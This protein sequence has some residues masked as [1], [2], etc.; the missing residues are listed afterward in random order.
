MNIKNSWRYIQTAAEET[1]SPVNLN[2]EPVELR[3][4][5]NNINFEFIPKPTIGGAKAEL[6]LN[7]FGV[8]NAGDTLSLTF[9]SNTITLVASQTPSYGEFLTTLGTNVT[10][11][12]KSCQSVGFELQSDFNINSAY[13]I[14]ADGVY[15]TITAITESPDF[16]ITVDTLPTNI[17][18]MYNNSGSAEFEYQNLV[19]YSVFN[20]LYVLDYVYGDQN[21]DKQTADFVAETTSQFFGD[22]IN[23][24]YQ[25]SLGDTVDV[26]LPKKVLSPTFNFKP[27][28]ETIKE[29]ILR[30]YV[31]LYGDYFRYV[32]NGEKKKRT[33][34][35]SSIRWVQN[36]AFNLLDAYDLTDYTLYP[37]T[38]TPFSF[39]TNDC[40]RYVTYNSHQYIQFIQKKQ[41]LPVGDLGIEVE[42]R[43][44]DGSTTTKQIG[45]IPSGVNGGNMSIDVS[46]LVLGLEADEVTAGVLIER[47]Y[48]R[49]YWT[50]GL[51]TYYSNRLQYEFRRDCNKNEQHLIWFNEFGGWDSLDFTGIE[52]ETLSRE[53]KSIEKALPANANNSTNGA[54][55]TELRKIYDIDVENNYTYVSEFHNANCYK[56]VESL[57]KSTSVFIW[58]ANISRYKNILIREFNFEWSGDRST[59]R[60]LITFNYSAQTNTIRR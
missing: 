6:K 1:D 25:L 48:V 10:E 21:I 19:D 37:N 54:S 41:I 30:P 60:L 18:V 4:A 52:T 8:I 58:D 34:G 11:R 53:T 40:I 57:V 47:Y 35:V 22:E 3:A 39:L 45:S 42:L 13:D 55:S 50:I 44:T 43:F 56:Y 33:Q 16:D 17:G 15:L 51:N 27:L 32:E 23:F 9:G 2:E 28:D 36:A 12:S 7:F 14:I 24:Q 38:T 26:V 20:E 5:E 49:V 31:L 46:P 29:S 59:F